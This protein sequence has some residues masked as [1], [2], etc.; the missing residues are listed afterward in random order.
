MEAT[1][2]ARHL[3]QS[4]YKLRFVMD[5]VRGKKVND[6]LTILRFT[7]KKA[8]RY[9]IKTI[10]SA[11]ANLSSSE[12][13]FDADKLYIKTAFVDGGTPMK[14]WRPA[15]MGRATP[16]LKRTSHITIIISDKKS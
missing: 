7:N 11:V 9:I 15:A 3:R 10:N 5:L 13:S 6:A 1:A 2:R 8:A 16:I 4:P 12:E 14:R